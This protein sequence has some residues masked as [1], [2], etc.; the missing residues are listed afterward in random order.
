MNRIGTFGWGFAYE[1]VFDAGAVS[2]E[3]LI[4][5]LSPEVAAATYTFLADEIVLSEECDC[6]FLFCNLHNCSLGLKLSPLMIV[7]FYIL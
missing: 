4:M 7:R 5:L 3:S 1:G 6:E 2:A